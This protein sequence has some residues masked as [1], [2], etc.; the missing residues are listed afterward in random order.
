MTATP[1]PDS[2]TP[3]E[4][5]APPVPTAEPEPALKI[6]SLGRRIAFGTLRTIPLIIVLV[7]LPWY[8]LRAAESA[9]LHSP[10]PVGAILAAGLLISVIS[11]LRYVARP[12]KAF[13]P[14]SVLASVVGL[15]YLL[16]LR[17]LA[18]FSVSAGQ[19][20]SISLTYSG[21]LTYALLVPLFGLLA[22]IVTT[23]EDFARPGE[24]V[25]Y[26]Y[27]AKS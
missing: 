9:G 15:V 21:L 11:A 23:V 24:R 17:S 7:I 14:L 20:M 8:G 2:S 12:T 16:Y 13:G 22:G 4:V 5:P 6:P 1:P 27:A 10:L 26:Q 25:R 19:G 18:E 3:N